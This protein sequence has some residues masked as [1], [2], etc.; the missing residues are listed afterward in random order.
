MNLRDIFFATAIVAAFLGLRQ[1]A[2]NSEDERFIGYGIFGIGIAVSIYVAFR[3][4]KVVYLFLFPGFV[5]FFLATSR[6]MEYEYL[7]PGT[8]YLRKHRI[9]AHY[10][11][12][13]E[14]NILAVIIVTF[15]VTII[16]GMIGVTIRTLLIKARKKA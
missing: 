2:I 6:A 9:Q 10:V 1:A 4:T 14:L 3:E 15:L 11:S 12:D 13:P 7:S 8:S 16:A 5:A